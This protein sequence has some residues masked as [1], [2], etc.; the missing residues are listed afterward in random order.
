MWSHGEENAMMVVGRG[1]IS[2]DGWEVDWFIKENLKK[3]NKESFHHA[4]NENGL[5][6]GE[7]ARLQSKQ[8]NEGSSLKGTALLPRMKE[9]LMELSLREELWR[10]KSRMAKREQL[11]FH[12]I[13]NGNRTHNQILQIID[14]ADWSQIWRRS[15]YTAAFK[16]FV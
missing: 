3:L 7:I 5:L 8:I 11:G 1:F 10:K 4:E 15:M 6:V 2:L 9:E 16:Q 13:A 12:W 14:L